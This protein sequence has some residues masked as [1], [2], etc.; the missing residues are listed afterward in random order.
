M[1]ATAESERR[2][3]PRRKLEVEVSLTSINDEYTAHTFALHDISLSGMAIS[4]PSL[5]PQVGDRLSLC[6]ADKLEPCD[7]DHAIE[8]TVVRCDGELIGVQFDFVGIHVLKDIQ[9]LLRDG[10]IF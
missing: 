9:R 2:R 4:S 5:V 7:S 3:H 10:R 6:L 8:A 1:L